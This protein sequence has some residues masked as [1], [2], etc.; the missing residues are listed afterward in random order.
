MINMDYK[1]FLLLY[2]VL[3]LKNLTA[4][5]LCITL[6]LKKYLYVKNNNYANRGVC[7]E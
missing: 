6:Y 5:I 1:A 3:H 7:V 4:A 2:L